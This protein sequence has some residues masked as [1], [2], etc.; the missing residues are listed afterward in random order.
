MFLFSNSTPSSPP[1]LPHTLFKSGKLI[2][3]KSII[4]LSCDTHLFLHRHTSLFLLI[5]YQ[6]RCHSNPSF[7]SKLPYQVTFNNVTYIFCTNLLR[8]MTRLYHMIRNASFL[9]SSS[10]KITNTSSSP[11]VLS[12]HCSHSK[13]Q[14]HSLHIYYNILHTRAVTVVSRWKFR[15]SNKKSTIK[16]KK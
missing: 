15:P 6:Y 16:G 1:L 12:R 11:Q 8:Y 2:G 4:L 7:I 10:S 14:Q 5:S 13:L 9:L 3:N